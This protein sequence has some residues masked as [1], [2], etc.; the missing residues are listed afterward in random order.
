MKSLRGGTHSTLT[1]TATLV[2][3]TLERIPGVS[4]ISP[5]IITKSSSR[6]GKRYIACAY[7]NAGMEMIISGQSVQKVAVHCNPDLAPHIF[8]ALSQHKKLSGFTFKTRVK[9][10][11]I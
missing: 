3:E 2:V 7:T 10:P 1:E 9:K 4:N 11:G 5:G 6:S 8:H